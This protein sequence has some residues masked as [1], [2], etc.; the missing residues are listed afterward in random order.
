[1]VRVSTGTGRYIY[2][3]HVRYV[4]APVAIYTL[5][6]YAMCGHLMY[7]RYIYVMHVRYVRAPVAIYTLCMYAMCGHRSLYIRYVCTLCA[8]TGCVR[9]CWQLETR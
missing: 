9:R 7:V 4:R 8:G 1:M 6:M 3:M 5:C 2:V